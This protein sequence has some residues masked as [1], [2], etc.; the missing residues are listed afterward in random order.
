M[1]ALAISFST[2]AS[3]GLIMIWRGSGI[4]IDASCEIGVERAVVVDA[5]VVDERRRGARR[6]DRAQL[7]L[8]VVQRLLHAVLACRFM[9]VVVAVIVRS[10]CVVPRGSPRTTRSMLPSS[11][12]LKTTTG[13]RFSMHSVIAVPSMTPRPL[14]EHLHVGELRQRARPS[15]S[16][17]G[18]AR[19]DAVDLGAP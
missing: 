9:I 3:K 19:V 12:M 8:E 2:E 6:A 13:S 14:L 15:G 5:D 7:L 11:N 17:F 4:E 10:G 1:I 18:S 16:R